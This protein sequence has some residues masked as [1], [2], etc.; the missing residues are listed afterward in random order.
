MDMDDIDYDNLPEDPQQAFLVIERAIRQTLYDRLRPLSHNDRPNVEYF[1]YMNHVRAAAEELG[2]SFLDDFGSTAYTNISEELF[3]N[4]IGEVDTYITRT[5]IAIGR[6]NKGYSVAFDTVSKRK[7]A[8]LLGQIREIVDTAELDDRKKE[9][10]YARIVALQTE[11][12]RSR[13]RFEAFGAYVI[14]AA[15]VLGEVG[16]ASSR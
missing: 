6:R 3:R 16:S 7:I 9:A 8:H 11:V 1:D 2:L 5:R 14:E 10:L 15:G 12:D 4:F 13:T